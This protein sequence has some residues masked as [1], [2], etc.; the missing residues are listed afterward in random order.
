MSDPLQK[1]AQKLNDEK[2]SALAKQEQEA[3]ARKREL[4]VVQTVFE[5]ACSIIATQA[6]R[7]LFKQHVTCKPFWGDQSDT[8]EWVRGELEVSADSLVLRHLVWIRAD[9]T[10]Q[11]SEYRLLIVGTGYGWALEIKTG[12]SSYDRHLGVG[13]GDAELVAENFFDVILRCG[14]ARISE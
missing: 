1:A 11:Y 9:N 14:W 12:S 2:R 10:T 4:E 8:E 13:P 3:A 5:Q 6:P 7:L